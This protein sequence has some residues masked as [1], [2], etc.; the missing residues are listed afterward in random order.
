MTH[1]LAASASSL[2]RS[3]AMAV[4]VATCAYILTAAPSTAMAEVTTAGA[5]GAGVGETNS[6]VETSKGTAADELG[7]WGF[8]G[9]TVFSLAAGVKGVADRVGERRDGGGGEGGG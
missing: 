9:Y 6:R 8:V 3:A 7:R 4:T 5:G 1:A 2:T